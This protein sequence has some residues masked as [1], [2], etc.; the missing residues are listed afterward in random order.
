MC[1]GLGSIEALAATDVI[2]LI[3]CWGIDLTNAFRE[4][5]PNLSQ[6]NLF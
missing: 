4:T 5:I 6:F 1:H 2:G 3:P